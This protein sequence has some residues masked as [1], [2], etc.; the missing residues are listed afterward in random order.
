MN[1]RPCRQEDALAALQSLCYNAIDM[2]TKDRVIGMEMMSH[3]TTTENIPPALDR[4][5]WLE[6][7]ISAISDNVRCVRQIV[8]P[9]VQV[10]AVVKANAYGH[11][12][13]QIAQAAMAGGASMLGVAC[14]SEAV[15]LRNM[16]IT[17][18]MLVLGYTPAWQAEAAVQHDIRVT[19]F[20]PDTAAA[21]SRAATTI[22]HP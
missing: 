2:L 14:L 1:A 22:G 19:L 4:P 5:T 10:M 3:P 9:E 17:I 18:P 15:M 7:D 21:L 8:G 16:G 20:D 13:T 11:G 6:I 12:I